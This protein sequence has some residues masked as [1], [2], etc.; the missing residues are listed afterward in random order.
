MADIEVIQGDIAA[1]DA[2]VLVNASNT[3]AWLGSGVSAA[4]ARSCGAGFQDHIRREL[5]ARFGGDMQPGDAFVT[6]AG[7]HPRAKWIAH[8]AVM[9]YRDGHEADAKPTLER[10]ER[11]TRRMLE[12]LEELP[13]P[14]VS[15]AMVALGTGTG[16]LGLRD[17]VRASAQALRDH[18]AARPSKIA[19]VR[20]V[21]WSIADYANM[22]DELSQLFPID[23]S[24]LPDDMRRFLAAL[25][26]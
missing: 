14:S 5:V 23:L 16:G 21:G 11:G 15:L 26:R 9:D 22:L 4:I 6:D 2:D 13:A 18:L 7:T 12:L 1:A 3:A 25:R 10:I 17:S 24:K 19:K 8:V 20:F